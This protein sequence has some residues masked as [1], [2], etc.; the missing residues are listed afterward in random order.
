MGKDYFYVSCTMIHLLKKSPVNTYQYQMV[1]RYAMDTLYRNRIET[2]ESL[3]YKTLAGLWNKN[4]AEIS[5]ACFHFRYYLNN[6]LH[7][8]LANWVSQ[9]IKSMAANCTM[10]DF[11]H[12]WIKWGKSREVISA[13]FLARRT[14][15]LEITCFL[16]YARL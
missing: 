13:G 5:C 7:N 8:C 12:K 15:I 3:I 11:N 4:N 16:V 10:V 9:G 6:D 1:I 2:R 14:S